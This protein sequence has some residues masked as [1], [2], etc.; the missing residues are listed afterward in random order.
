MERLTDAEPIRLPGLPV[1]V[2]W[3]R[4]RSEECMALPRKLRHLQKGKPGL[5][6]RGRL[7]DMGSLKTDTRERSGSAPGTTGKDLIA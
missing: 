5:C 4:I 3:D 6:R 7:V 1:R 2:P